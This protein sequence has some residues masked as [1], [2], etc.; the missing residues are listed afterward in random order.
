MRIV[1]NQSYKYG[2]DKTI[3]FDQIYHKP[4]FEEMTQKFTVLNGNFE[5]LPAL[6]VR[7]EEFFN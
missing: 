5:K 2:K 3:P 1:I 7:K 6:F 4:P